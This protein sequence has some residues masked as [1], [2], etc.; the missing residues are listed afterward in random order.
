MT[1]CI[2]DVAFHKCGGRHRRLA[3]DDVDSADPGLSLLIAVKALPHVSESHLLMRSVASEDSLLY[4]GGEAR[5]LI[6]CEIGR[7][8]SV[9]ACG[10]SCWVLL[11]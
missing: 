8:L 2:I 7:V 6:I 9:K 5:L 4:L 11:R 1:G 3:G 10:Y